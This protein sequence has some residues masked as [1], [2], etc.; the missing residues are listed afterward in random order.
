[1]KM[2]VDWVVKAVQYVAFKSEYEDVF[3]ELNKGR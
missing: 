3:L 1:M 2:R